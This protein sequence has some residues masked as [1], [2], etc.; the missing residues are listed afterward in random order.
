M[1]VRVRVRGRVKVRVRVRV[2]VGVGA[3]L[4]GG[5]DLEED[6]GRLGVGGECD[7]QV[8]GLWGLRLG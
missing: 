2:R 7:A 1:R 3:V 5:V 4:Q 8:P 6:L